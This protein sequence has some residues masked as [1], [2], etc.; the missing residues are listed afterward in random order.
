MTD[1]IGDKL[2]GRIGDMS[3]VTWDVCDMC[4][5]VVKVAVRLINVNTDVTVVCDDCID[6]MSALM[7]EIKGES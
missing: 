1:K 6:K 4:G 3:V 5:Y 7:G 2:S